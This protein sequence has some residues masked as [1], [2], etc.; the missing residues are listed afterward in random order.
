MPAPSILVIASSNVD[1][2]MHL[3]S[4]PQR[5]E[6]V[7][8]GTFIQTF[9]GKGANQAMAA[10]RAGRN[11]TFVR[12]IGGERYASIMEENFQKDAISTQ[13]IVR[14]FGQRS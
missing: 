13:H 5:G 9:G 4:L 6:T 1:F 10:A 14:D 8:D 11:V 7:T 12:A 2:V 3:P